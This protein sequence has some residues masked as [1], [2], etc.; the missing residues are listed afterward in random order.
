MEKRILFLSCLIIFIN[1]AQNLACLKEE[2]K[3][4]G[5][6]KVVVKCLAK[7]LSLNILILI[8]LQIQKCHC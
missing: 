4:V 3:H 7:K 8:T 1:D 2:L 5:K 6:E